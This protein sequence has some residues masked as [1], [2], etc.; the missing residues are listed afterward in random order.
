MKHAF[1]DGSLSTAL[2]GIH[3]IVVLLRSSPKL[4]ST[5]QKACADANIECSSPIIDVITRWCNQEAMTTRFANL[6]V[7]I[8]RIVAVEA[9]PKLTDWTKW[10]ESLVIA[11]KGL[12]TLQRVLPILVEMSQWTQILSRREIKT[13]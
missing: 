7:A 10:D 8:Q 3:D 11:E 13:S 2:I 9:F 6:F 12:A 4:K 5:L 1:E